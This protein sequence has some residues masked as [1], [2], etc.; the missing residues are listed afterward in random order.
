MVKK[1]R[2]ILYL[3]T[4]FNIL[5]SF[6][7]LPNIRGDTSI[8]VTTPLAGSVFQTGESCTIRWIYNQESFIDIYLYKGYSQVR[9]IAL[10]I[11][12]R[13]GFVWTIPGIVGE[14]DNFRIKV[15]DHNDPSVYDYSDYFTIT[16][17]PSI[18]VTTPE[19]VWGMGSR[20]E[21]MW[22]SSGTISSVDIYLC[23]QSEVQ[24][25]IVSGTA[26]EG[27]FYWTVPQT[28][29]ESSSYRILIIDSEDSSVYDFSGFFIIESASNN[30]DD[31]GDDD[32]NNFP[33]NDF[34]SI[35]GL[36]LEITYCIICTMIVIL[37]ILIKI[38]LNKKTKFQ[39]NYCY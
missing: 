33:N 25:A 12:N 27:S 38:S 35:L 4:I 14:G 30:E 3:F 22:G 2:E 1:K 18:S 23:I 9:T 15:V 16:Y 37:A 11:I 13:H 20:Y 6:S 24:V 29:T 21:I 7:I 5:L 28:L 8:T 39:H 26:N 19:S 36:N 31:N 32:N 10:G 17:P 34:D